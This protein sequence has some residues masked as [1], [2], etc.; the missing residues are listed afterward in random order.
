MSAISSKYLGDKPAFRK[1]ALENGY[2]INPQFLVELAGFINLFQLT[3]QMSI[4]WFKQADK[5]ARE[6]VLDL[7]LLLDSTRAMR[8]FESAIGYSPKVLSNEHRKRCIET[9]IGFGQTDKAKALGLTDDQK[10]NAENPFRI[11]L[12]TNEQ[13]TQWLE[14]FFGLEHQHTLS[15]AEDR[16]SHP[17]DSFEITNSRQNI[18][19]EATTVVVIAQRPGKQIIRSVRSVL[20][21]AENPLEIIVMQQLDIENGYRSPI[22][23]QKFSPN[24]KTMLINEDL[25]RHQILN[26]ALDESSGKYLCILNQGE[27]LHPDALGLL[28]SKAKKAPVAIALKKHIGLGFELTQTES[29][30]ALIN[31]PLAKNFGYFDHVRVNSLEGFIQRLRPKKQLQQTLCWSTDEKP[32]EQLVQD[33]TRHYLALQNSFVDSKSRPFVTDSPI[34]SF[35]APRPVRFGFKLSV[36]RRELDLIIAMD[37]TNKDSLAKL[38]DLVSDDLLIGIWDLNPFWSR[39]RLVIAKNLLNKMNSRQVQFVYPEERISVDRLL[40]LD[41]LALESQNPKRK[42]RWDVVDFEFN[43]DFLTSL[44]TLFPVSEV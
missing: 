10:K 43:K 33:A 12:S 13:K 15:F 17:V 3:D 38:N 4:S 7:A 19:L 37:M 18:N 2:G 20:A 41:P 16:F 25:N 14:S 30:V 35:Y 31:K 32:E 21:S 39:R 9:F 28:K 26:R 8:I 6:A 11:H 5:K 23:V 24:V 36:N 42:P 44:K 1:R 29:E 40:V 34:R 22:D 27:I